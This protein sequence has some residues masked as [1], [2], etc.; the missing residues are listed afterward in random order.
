[1]SAE[2]VLLDTS[3]WI[4]YFRDTDTVLSAHIDEIITQ[5]TARI[6][7]LVL[8]ELLQGAK[9]ERE[10]TELSELA[11]AIKRLNE[12]HDAWEQA[13]KLGYRLR[14]QGQTIHIN[15]C[16]IA[17]LAL[18]EDCELLTLDKHFLVIEKHEK[19]KLYK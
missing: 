1:M 15:D 10:I 2:P 7:G 18:A 3:A 14:M 9:S 6:C 17:I 13:G 16:Y 5:D 12:P 11:R 19:L 4:A 8:A